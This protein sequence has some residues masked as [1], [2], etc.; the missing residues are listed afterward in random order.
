MDMKIT[1]GTTPTLNFILPF[2]YNMDDIRLTFR[3]NGEIIKQ[4]EKDDMVITPILTETENSNITD[5][6]YGD[7]F[8]S[9]DYDAE[10]LESKDDNNEVYCNCS[11]IMSQEDTLSFGFYP[12]AE[13]NIAISQFKILIGGE[14]YVSDPV[15]FRVYGDLDGNIIGEG[16]EE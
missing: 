3:Q 6:N 1:R 2:D 9:N 4:Y 11:I 5:E 8:S 12:A 13:K 7:G 16:N 15:N 10:R 14:V